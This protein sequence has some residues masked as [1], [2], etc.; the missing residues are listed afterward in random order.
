M[1]LLN[2]PVIRVL[3]LL[4]GRRMPAFAQGQPP[5]EALWLALLLILAWRVAADWW[6]AEPPREW[7]N[8]GFIPFFCDLTLTWLFCYLLTRG[9]WC[10]QSPWLALSLVFEVSFLF[11]PVSAGLEYFAKQ[12]VA[13]RYLHVA[14]GCFVAWFALVMILLLYQLLDYRKGLAFVFT[15]L[16]FVVVMAPTG[17]LNYSNYKFWYQDTSA[18]V[19]KAEAQRIK[20]YEKIFFSQDAL[21]NQES[22]QL[23]AG[24]SG[25]VDLFYLGFGSYASQRV[26]KKEVEYLQQLAEKE[27]PGKKRSLLLINHRDTLDTVPLAIHHNL[28][29]ALRGVASHMNLDEDILFVYLTSHGSKDHTLAI[30]FYPLELVDLTPAMLKAALDDA[31][32]RWRVLVISACYSGGFVEPLKN[33][34]TVIVTAAD[35]DHTSF[36]CSDDNDFTYFGEA[37]LRDQL[38]RGVPMLEAFPRAIAAIKERETQE[39]KTHSNPQLWVGPAVAAQVQRY[40]LQKTLPLESREL[41]GT[42]AP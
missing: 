26:F 38:M 1:K 32:I 29:T 24:T 35:A 9:A 28:Q 17:Y 12:D 5:R 22:E 39:K 14:V 30:S 27:Q 11:E 34:E 16:F 40:E 23:T 42:R 21:V 36:G 10:T 19:A 18:Q 41:E 8:W 31:G 7:S 33:D 25:V 20:D 4:L 13:M 3:P 15:I 37:V 6:L 2:L